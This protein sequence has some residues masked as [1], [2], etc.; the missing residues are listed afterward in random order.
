MDW[1]YIA[2]GI[3]IIVGAAF[4]RWSF[5]TI[6]KGVC[7]VSKQPLVLWKSFNAWRKKRAIP[8]TI[9]SDGKTF[10]QTVKAP[11]SW[12]LGLQLPQPLR[13]RINRWLGRIK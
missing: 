10:V 3:I 1:K 6:F 12:R 9:K 7:W 4:I 8:K 2:A 5:K 11:L 13:F